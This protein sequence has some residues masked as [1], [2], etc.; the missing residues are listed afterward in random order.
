MSDYSG[1]EEP[2]VVQKVIKQIAIQTSRGSGN[3]NQII[4]QIWI[5]IKN[6][7][8]DFANINILFVIK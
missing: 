5:L 3:V 7:K 4:N 1:S 2:S 8:S 6:S